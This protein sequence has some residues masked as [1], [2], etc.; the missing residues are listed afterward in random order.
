MN[1]AIAEA[2]PESTGNLPAESNAFIGRERDL[3][4]LTSILDRVRAVTLCG[5]GG[6]GKTR[7]ALRLGLDLAAGYPD[8]VWIADQADAESPDRLVPL[9]AASLGIRAEPDRPLDRTL[10]EA[11][12][13]RAMLLILDTCEHLVAESAELVEWLLGSCPGLRVIA[14]SR[15]PLRVRGEVIWRVPPLGLP[16]REGA[17]FDSGP[18]VEGRETDRQELA[19]PAR[20]IASSEAVRLFMARATAARPDFELSVSNASV[21]AEI[22][23][24]LDGVPLAIELA[25]ARIRT[26]SADQI[27][28]RL[29]GR[30]ELLAVGD[31]TAPLRQQTLRATVDWSYDL[32]TQP[33]RLLLSRLAVFSGWCLEMAEEV[34]ADDAIPAIDVLDLLTALIDKSLVTVEYQPDGA[35]RY[36]LLGTVR[37]FAIGQVTDPAELERMRAAHRDCMLAL[38]DGMMRSAVLRDDP[39]WQERVATYHRAMTDWANLRLALAYC[40]DHDDAEKG[41]R[42]CHAMRIA[43]LLAGDQSAAAWLDRFL[44]STAAVPAGLTSRA[45]V[46]RAEIAFEQQ[47]YQDAERYALAAL[48]PGL[49]S[50]DGSPDGST[51]GAQR[52]LALTALLAGRTQDALARVDEAVA[53]A[54]QRSDAWEAGISLAVRAGLVA[55]QGDL[56]GAKL[57]YQQALD[58]LGEGRGWGVANVRYGLGR[59]AIAT[60]DPAGAARYF[61]EALTIYRQI[62]AR[63][64][65]TRCLACL[66]QL[67]LDSRDL[68]AA[69]ARLTECMRL[70]LI[71]G[72]RLAIARGLAALASLHAASDD[73]EAAVRL[74]G[75]A[76]MLFAAIAVSHRRLDTLIDEASAKLGAPAVAELL[77]RGR[78]L[79]PHQAAVEAMQALASQ[80]LAMQAPT[81]QPARAAGND[82][83][84]PAGAQPAGTE[85][86]DA[87]PASAPPASQPGPSERWPAPSAPSARDASSGQHWPGPL[88]DRERQVALLISQGLSNR[89]IGEQ[90]EI[91][92]TTAARHVANIFVKLGFT[93]RTQVV[94]W[95][96]NSSH[97]ANLP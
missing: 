74:A 14:T 16:A 21:V 15:E 53:I 84:Q 24:T 29:A 67:A 8:G 50:P 49:A 93:S 48:S 83:A 44:N 43:W 46:V 66:G 22:C 18:S 88:T 9:L 34:C 33:E 78:D 58:V 68:D 17:A 27:R 89:A 95:V 92:T 1:I 20:V 30:F 75:T 45:L 40:A 59:L 31:R 19:D 56:A 85:A 91:T 90:L 64:Q 60:G 77:A 86:A 57:A 47:E 7:L 63:P 97:A 39:S 79:S 2:R 81:R 70:S 54:R 51:A 28:L 36:R 32:L 25:A 62:G 37:Q 23:R 5:P 72:Q 10:A 61:G 42:L 82:D 11:M 35:I 12:R 13:P 65:M 55:S 80:A 87:P 3:V 4:D 52:M 38:A 41:L 71:T 73:L 96:L 6:I 26:L 76:Q 69:R 94:A